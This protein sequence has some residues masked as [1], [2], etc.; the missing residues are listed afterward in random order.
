MEKQAER[1]G[2]LVLVA[3]AALATGCGND[4]S[5]C[6]ASNVQPSEC[7]PKNADGRRWGA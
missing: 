7:G 4:S 5:P 1:R 6:S 2:V 3:I